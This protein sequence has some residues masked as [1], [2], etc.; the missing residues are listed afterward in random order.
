MTA[1]EDRI[2]ALPLWRGAI[3]IAPLKGGLSNEIWLVTDAAGRHVV[4]FGKDF[5][6]HHV[7]REREA[8]TARAAHAGRL[9]A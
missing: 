1:S 2:R 6:F 8:M 5:P 9:R 4:R 7:V 3:E